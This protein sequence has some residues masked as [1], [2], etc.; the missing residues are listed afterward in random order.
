MHFYSPSQRAFYNTNVNRHIPDDA[1][2]LSQA[3]LVELL[4]GQS[5]GRFI[6]PDEGGRPTLVDQ[7]IT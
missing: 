6:M 5:S 2:Q 7:Q 3:Y 1:V 4:D